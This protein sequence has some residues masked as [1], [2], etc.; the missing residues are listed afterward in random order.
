MTCATGYEQIADTTI[1]A[2]CPT[3][4]AAF[5]LAGCEA[6]AACSTATLP[7]GY[8]AATGTPSCAGTC[9]FPADLAACGVENACT[10]TTADA[11]AALGY[12]AGG[13][14]T[15]TT[16][17]ALG[18]VTCAAGY[19]GTPAVTCPTDGEA[20]VFAGCEA[21]TV[22]QY[23]TDAKDTDADEDTNLD[24]F[25]CDTET[26]VLTDVAE[27][28]TVTAGSGTCALTAA[29]TYQTLQYMEG[30]VTPAT[31]NHCTA[32]AG[33]AN[34][35]TEMATT[36]VAADKTACE[37]VTAL[38]TNAA[39]VAVQKAAGGGAACTYNEPP[40][41]CAYTIVEADCPDA[42][43][44]AAEDKTSGVSAVAPLAAVAALV[45]VLA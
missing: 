3:D 6:D 18:T 40:T 9:D 13:T 33:T 8:K 37:A 22:A 10:A 45:A 19:T 28:C 2:T 25:E 14:A 34:A 5:V 1:E 39:C 42:A 21:K 30:G 35:C 15:G 4:G 31:V 23:C 26:Y 32:T 20:F 44:P 24:N 12:V 27:A 41:T 7:S 29:T 38:D 16:V 36:S 43:D 11:I 17:T